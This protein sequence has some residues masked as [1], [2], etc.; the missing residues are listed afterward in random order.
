MDCTKTITHVSL[1]AGYGGIDLGLE[2]ALGDVRTV[3]FCEIEAFA[4]SNL[5]AKMEGGSGGPLIAPAPIWT[6]IKSFP[7]SA[8]RGKVDIL[9]GGFPCQPFSGAGAREADR[10]PR[11]L[12]PYILKGISELGGPPLVLLENVEGIIGS[13]LKGDDW[14]DPAGTPVLHHVL[15][16]LERLGYD[17]TAGV[18]SAR[19]VGAS[20]I[21]RRVIILATNLSP[22]GR[23]LVSR[24]LEANFREPR[25][26]PPAPR[27]AEQYAWEPP[28]V[29]VEGVND[30]ADSRI[31]EIRM[32][33]N[34]VV[35]DTVSRAFKVLWE[36]LS[37]VGDADG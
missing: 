21:R 28:R 13:A 22:A 3:A 24:R 35:P 4:V 27:G 31:H 23:G 30:N 15:R 14:R 29:V 1:C 32:L 8:F 2:R 33:G 11:H 20:H 19:E 6:D 25:A 9:S 34:G 7:W 5:V 18:F 36:R 26:V 12:F 37:T 16:E 17:S 10:D